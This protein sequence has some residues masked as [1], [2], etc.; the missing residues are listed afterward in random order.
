MKNVLLLVLLVGSLFAKNVEHSAENQVSQDYSQAESENGLYPLTYEDLEISRDGIF[1]N[2]HGRSIQ[3]RGVLQ[4]SDG[5]LFGTTS[6][7]SI[8]WKC[9]KCKYQN[10]PIRNTCAGCGYRPNAG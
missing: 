3:L 7:W 8:T 2:L 5:N 4:D 9:P 1:L 10:S 6:D